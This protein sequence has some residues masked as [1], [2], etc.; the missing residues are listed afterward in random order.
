MTKNPFNNTSILDFFFL[1]IVVLL[2]LFLVAVGILN[3]FVSKEIYNDLKTESLIL[4]DVRY[5]PI[6]SGF[7]FLRRMTQ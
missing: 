3:E 2:S 7:L 6:N 1:C 5:S 4:K